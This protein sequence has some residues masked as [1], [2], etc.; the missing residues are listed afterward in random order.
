MW[1]Y[2]RISWVSLTQIWLN[3]FSKTKLE[4]GACFPP[5]ALA[6]FVFSILYPCEQ[7]PSSSWFWYFINSNSA[8]TIIFSR[9]L[10]ARELLQNRHLAAKCEFNSSHFELVSGAIFLSLF[11]C[12]VTAATEHFAIT[13]TE[14]RVRG[15]LFLSLYVLSQM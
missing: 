10:R 14:R 13:I 11:P 4:L 5:D 6:V 3:Y 12:A 8:Q 1:A 15:L 7:A 9:F 2:T